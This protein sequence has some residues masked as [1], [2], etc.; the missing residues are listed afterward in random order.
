M[1][2]IDAEGEA[3]YIHLDA[4][5]PAERD[6]REAKD[7]QLRARAAGQLRDGQCAE[8]ILADCGGRQVDAQLRRR[9]QHVRCKGIRVRARPYPVGALPWIALNRGLDA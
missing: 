8:V 4:L 1:H 6:T 9:A 5:L 7:V 2:W 3:Q